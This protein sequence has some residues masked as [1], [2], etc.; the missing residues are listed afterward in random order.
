M[1]SPGNV[2]DEGT[3]KDSGRDSRSDDNAGASHEKEAAETSAAGAE[4]AR[5]AG[6]SPKLDLTNVTTEELVGQL[7]LVVEQLEKLMEEA[8][9][10]IN[11]IGEPNL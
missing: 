10:R 1:Q 3:G 5:A 8:D 6:G 9:R 2:T 11:E 4:E 7:S